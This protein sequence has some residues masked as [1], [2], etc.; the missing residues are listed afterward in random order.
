MLSGAVLAAGILV[1]TQPEVA[2]Y[3]L[4]VQA[5]R[6]ELPDAQV[7]DV[8]DAAACAAAFQ[9]APEV[10]IA[11]GTKAFDLAKARLPATPIVAAAVLGPDA[12][13]R[14]DVTAVPLE[15]RGAE[16]LRALAALAPSVRKVMVI[17][18]PSSAGA[19]AELKQAAASSGLT[20]EFRALVELS[21][22]QQL[23]RSVLA[24]RDAVWLLPDTRLARPEIVRFMVSTCL[25][26][27]VALV[28][29]LEAMTRAGALASV[30]A[31]FHAI[32]KV[33]VRLAAQLREKHAGAVP[34]EF[35]AGK[36]SVNARTREVLRLP[37]EVPA[38]Y[39]VIR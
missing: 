10:A 27:R 4:V 30:S 22:F 2:Q 20:V 37:G 26:Q 21:S 31:D 24:G 35:A 16:G 32:G 6:A 39:A 18:P 28:G 29:F 3:A 13:G 7:A 36:V 33:A 19:V 14:A 1:L 9:T 23:F 25:E 11:V 34:F 12:G 17:F 15:P 8:G 5:V 38:G